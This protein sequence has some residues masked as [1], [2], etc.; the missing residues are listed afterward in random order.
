M[1]IQESAQLHQQTL[2]FNSTRRPEVW[3]PGPCSKAPPTLTLA[4]SAALIYGARRRRKVGG[5][6]EA[7]AIQAFRDSCA[8]YDTG[9]PDSDAS[10]DNDRPQ[11]KR[12]QISYS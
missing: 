10:L 4:A 6:N 3:R 12:T 5:I 11:I 9:D 2:S 7:K 8:H 1:S